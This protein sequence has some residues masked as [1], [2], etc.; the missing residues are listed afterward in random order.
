MESKM[1]KIIQ[2]VL[3][4]T[5]CAVLAMP[6]MAGQANSAANKQV[7]KHIQSGKTNYVEYGSLYD[8][9][10]KLKRARS[11]FAAAMKAVPAFAPENTPQNYLEA[12]TFYNS[13]YSVYQKR[14]PTEQASIAQWKQEDGLTNVGATRPASCPVKLNWA[15]HAAPDVQSIDVQNGKGHGTI[16]VVYDIGATGK[17]TRISIG[18]ALWM[19]GNKGNQMSQ[20]YANA[21]VNA[22]KDWQLADAA[23]MPEACRVNRIATFNFEHSPITSKYMNGVGA[24]GKRS[25]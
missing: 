23:N 17:I 1:H 6:A 8:L 15:S 12:L 21:A 19:Q 10:K 11:D 2:T 24:S 16:S 9:R 14:F 7:A 4:G 3:A 20:A 18:G 13:V 25:S 5:C 22:V